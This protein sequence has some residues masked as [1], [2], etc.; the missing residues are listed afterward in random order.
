MTQSGDP[1]ENAVAERINGIIKGE[2]MNL[3]QVTSLI[4]GQ[5]CLEESVALYNNERPHMSIGMLTPENVHSNNIKTEKL[6]K[7]KRQQNV[8]SAPHPTSPI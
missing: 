2:Y 4:Q 5:Q 6:W 3:Y 8:I 1:L 7:T